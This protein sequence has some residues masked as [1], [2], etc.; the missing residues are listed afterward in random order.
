MLMLIALIFEMLILAIF[1]RKICTSCKVNAPQ[2]LKDFSEVLRLL[3]FNKSRQLL[4][5]FL[6]SI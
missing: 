4:T 3:T 2:A 6:G 1:Q 5:S